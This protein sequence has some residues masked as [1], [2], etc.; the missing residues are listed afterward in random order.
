MITWT[1]L[2]LKIS[3]H[4]NIPIILWSK[5]WNKKSVLLS[6]Q[7]FILYK[8]KT[9]KQKVKEKNQF[10]NGPKLRIGT[11]IKKTPDSSPYLLNS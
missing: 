5:W 11:L 4:Q 8:N 10:K 2:K 3:V 6:K 9:T 7:E 1:T